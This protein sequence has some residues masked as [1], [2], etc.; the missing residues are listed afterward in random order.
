M[1][2]GKD[3]ILT[4]HVGSLH[5]PPDLL[6]ML[7]AQE[8]AEVVDAA[9]LDR[10]TAE[11]T[12]R[13]VRRQV[14]SGVDVV[15]DGEQGKVS[16]NNYVRARISGFDGPGRPRSPG[17]DDRVFPGWAKLSSGPRTLV[18]SNNAP[19]SWKDFSALER[20][21]RNLKAAVASVSPQPTEV[22]MTSV[23][24]GTIVNNLPTIYYP[25]NQAY[26]FALADVLQREYR[27]IVD[28]GF[29]LQVDAPDLGLHDTF[30]PDLSVAEFRDVAA[31]YVEAINRAIRGLPSDQV[32]MHV[33]WGAGERPAH[34]NIPVQDIIDI[35]LE[36]H[37]GALSIV[38][39]NGH[40][41]HEYHVWE[42]TQLPDGMLLIPGVID[43]TTNIIEHPEVVAERIIRFAD[44]V[45]KQNIV[46]GVDCGF[47]RPAVDEDV[48]YAKLQALSDGATL[49]SARLWAAVRA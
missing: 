23:S 20:D 47:G 49:A 16:F 37:V 25:N 42:T 13:V 46:A 30:Y 2:H 22:F 21:I 45:G 44:R 3:R 7:Q 28:A 24:P 14:Q 4:T 41:E 34:R 5:R 31:M 27:A 10:A 40:H 38:G 12:A 9:A 33:C 19:V 36:A 39:A 15:N 29:I 11:A 1:K 17:L 35:V 26:A 48:A 43:S 8:R 32:R 6:R 18:A